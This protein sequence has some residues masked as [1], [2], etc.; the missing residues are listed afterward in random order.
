MVR[1]APGEAEV[2]LV[3]QPRGCL[4]DKLHEGVGGVGL[5]SNNSYVAPT[6]A[7]PHQLLVH[8]LRAESKK[9]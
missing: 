6:M 8:S 1:R 2:M 9:R 4:M 5:K 7:T 3:T